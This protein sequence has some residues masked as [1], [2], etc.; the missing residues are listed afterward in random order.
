MKILLGKLYVYRDMNRKCDVDM[1]SFLN[2]SDFQTF[3][4]VSGCLCF[5]FVVFVFSFFFF[6]LYCFVVLLFF[7]LYLSLLYS[8]LLCILK[9][10]TSNIK[11]KNS[12]NHSESKQ[13]WENNNKKKKKKEICILHKNND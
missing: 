13:N 10:T 9:K 6:F 8:L 2:C 1:G 7:L 12:Q 3:Q 5:V 4:I 11:F